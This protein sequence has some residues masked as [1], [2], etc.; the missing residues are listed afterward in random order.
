M[1]ELKDKRLKKTLN[2][3]KGNKIIVVIDETGD[4]KKGKKLIMWQDN[5]E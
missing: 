1:I 2:A 4:R 3:L 5:I